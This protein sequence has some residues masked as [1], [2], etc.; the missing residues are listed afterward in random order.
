M[1]IAEQEAC[2]TAS[3]AMLMPKLLTALRGPRGIFIMS[4]IMDCLFWGTLCRQ[5]RSCSV[6]L[7][8]SLN[9]LAGD[10]VLLKIDRPEA[11]FHEG[12]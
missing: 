10:P 9:F 12:P 4:T 5:R 7:S 6:L 1:P 8:T 3:V 11:R 2:E